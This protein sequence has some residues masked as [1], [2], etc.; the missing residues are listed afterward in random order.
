MNTAKSL[1]A[2]LALGSSMAM[3]E[4][5]QPESPTLPDGSSATMDDMIAGQ[6]AVKALRSLPMTTLG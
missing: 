5:V 1:L 6:L 2:L 4:C 3:A